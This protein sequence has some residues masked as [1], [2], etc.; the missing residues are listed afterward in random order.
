MEC[1]T[2]A[3]RAGRLF[4][5]ALYPPICRHCGDSFRDGLSNILCAP[6]FDSARAYDEPACAH[7]GLGLLPGAFEGARVVRCVECGDE[8]YHLDLVKAVGPY[9]GPLRLAHHA[10][11]FEGMEHLAGRLAGRMAMKIRAFEGVEALVP[12]PL[13]SERERERGYHPA[14]LLAREIARS[15][16]L[17][18][19]EALRKITS[20]PAQVSLDREERLRNLDGVFEP[21]RKTA[22]PD[23]VVLVD[24]V[25]TTGGTLEECA[26]TLKLAGAGW[27]GAIVLGRTEQRV[28]KREGGR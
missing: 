4:A 5:D 10:F 20:T 15:S 26:K 3:R 8:E 28:T 16:G 18:V 2:L 14:R 1:A 13:S 6:C 24:D 11:K 9:E 7:C 25:Y 12:V 21:E 19:V 23:R 17:R 22:I 27:V